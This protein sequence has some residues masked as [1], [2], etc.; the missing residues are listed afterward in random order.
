MGDLFL[1]Y[2]SIQMAKKQTAHEFID[3]QLILEQ[4]Y[5]TLRAHQHTRLNVCGA[6]ENRHAA[7]A[8][9]NNLLS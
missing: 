2:F 6:N 4:T 3:N 1:N 9:E 7:R 5:T 8:T